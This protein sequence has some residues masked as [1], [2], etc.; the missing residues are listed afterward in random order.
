M[1][2]YIAVLEL[3]GFLGTDGFKKIIFAMMLSRFPRQ[4]ENLS[5]SERNQFRSDG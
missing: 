5:L 2:N 3:F 4:V 1:V